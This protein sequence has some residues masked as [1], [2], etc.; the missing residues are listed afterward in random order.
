MMFDA[1]L[2]SF[3]ALQDVASPPLEALRVGWHH[4]GIQE[5]SRLEAV[6]P[7]LVH[8]LLRDVPR[9]RKAA[10]DEGE[11]TDLRVFV[12]E[13]CR[14]DAQGVAQVDAASDQRDGSQILPQSSGETGDLLLASFSC[15]SKVFNGDF[16]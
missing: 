12:E 16:M 8:H 10:G 13:L 15:A 1:L 4:L 6:L 7:Q 11:A 2:L 3:D 5:L 14:P 9:G